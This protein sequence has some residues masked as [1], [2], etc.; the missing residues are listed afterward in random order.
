MNIDYEI[1]EE[2]EHEEGYGQARSD[3]CRIT[4]EGIIEIQ[5]EPGAWPYRIRAS[6]LDQ[7]TGFAEW[8]AHLSRKLWFTPEVCADF[9]T[10]VCRL[11]SEAPDEWADYVRRSA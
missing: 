6:D 8:V 11:K 9:T 10:F 2:Y 1:E 5:D 4:S 7:M 3:F